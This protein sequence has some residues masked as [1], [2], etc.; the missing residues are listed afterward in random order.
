M[1]LPRD[2]EDYLK[3]GIAKKISPDRS[4]AFYLVEESQN[5]LYALNEIIRKIGIN[6]KNANALIKESY[7]IIMELIRAKMFLDGFSASGNF[8]HEAEIS[9]LKKLNFSKNEISFLNE[10]RFFRNSVTYYGKILDQDY[11]KKVIDF[12]YFAHPKLK[13]KINE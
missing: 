3:Q 12:L 8:A 5:S 10:L 4:R 9:Y 2:F 11:A 6:N 7:D 1:R 13:N